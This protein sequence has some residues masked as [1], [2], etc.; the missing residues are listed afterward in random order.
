MKLQVDHFDQVRIKSAEPFLLNEAAIIVLWLIDSYII[1]STD[2]YAGLYSIC[3]GFPFYKTLAN[4]PM[5]LELNMPGVLVFK[6]EDFNFTK[7]FTI[8]TNDNYIVCY[9]SITMIWMFMNAM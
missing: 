1:G 4:P 2:D 6:I 3:A 9:L 7:T 8:N 5:L